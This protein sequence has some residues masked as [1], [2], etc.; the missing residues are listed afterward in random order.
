MSKRSLR[1]IYLS[2][3]SNNT[4]SSILSENNKDF[5]DPLNLIFSIIE[6]DDLL[7]MNG[8]KINHRSYEFVLIVNF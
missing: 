8:I 5:N 4:G 2:F 3:Q 6:N 1:E 7:N